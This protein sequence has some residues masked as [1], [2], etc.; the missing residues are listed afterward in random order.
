MEP[1]RQPQPRRAPRLLAVDPG[2]RRTGIALSDE[3]GLFAHPRPAIV[4]NGRHSLVAALRNVVEAEGV[5]EV[6][7]G[8]PL[9]LSGRESEQTTRSRALIAEL[10]QQIGVPVTEWDERLSSAE[11]ARRVPSRRH[12]TGELDSEA[13][14]IILQAVLDSRRGALVT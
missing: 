2:E 13:A 10:R 1:A 8:L 11:A 5:S 12:R 7:V 3:L 9:S 14:S 6:V 4:A